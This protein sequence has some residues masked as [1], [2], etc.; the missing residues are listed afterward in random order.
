MWPDAK[1]VSY[2]YFPKQTRILKCSACL[3]SQSVRVIIITVCLYISR[4]IE[5]K[6]DGYAIPQ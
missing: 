4:I 3:K 2:L 5:K 6:D 1:C